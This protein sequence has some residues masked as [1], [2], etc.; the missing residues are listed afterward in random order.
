MSGTPT[1]NATR[2]LAA[3]MFSDIVGY[4]AIMGRDE[5]EALRAL[6]AHRGALRTLLPK[7]NGRLIG[8][9]GDGTLSSFHSAI[10][11]VNCAREVQ[12][13]A[14][15][16]SPELRLRI[17]IHLGD[18]VFT[19]STVLGDGVNVASRI[20]A[21][22]EPGGIC[23]SEHIYDAIRNKPGI[24][25]KN[26]G[27]KRLKNVARPIRV[28][29]LQSQ[30]VLDTIPRLRERIAGRTLAVGVVLLTIA[31]FA[32]AYAYRTRIERTVRERV[33]AAKATKATVA[34]LPFVNLSASKDDEYFSDGMTDEIIGDL[35]KI[36]GL[37]VVARSSSFAFKGQN[38]DAKRIAKLLHVKNLLEGSVRRS[39]DKVRIEVDLIDAGSGFSIWSESY[40]RDR[41]DIFAI[42][43]DVA[44]SVAEKLKVSLLPE[45]AA[46]VEKKPTDNHDAYDLYLRG[47]YF[48]NLFSEEDDLKAIAY[49][50]RAIALDP[51]FALA[52]AALA[53]VYVN[54]TDWHFAPRESEPIVKTESERALALDDRLAEP[55]GTLGAYMIQY[56]WDWPAA[57][58]EYRRAIEIAPDD[59]ETHGFYGFA[60]GYM[61]RY[62]DA[63]R[64]LQRAFEVDPL[65][66]IGFVFTGDVYAM[67]RDYARARQCYQRV[68]DMDPYSWVGYFDRGRLSSYEGNLPAAIEDIEKAVTLTDNP[69]V[70]GVLGPLYARAGRRADTLK[71]LAELRDASK[72]RFVS[73]VIFFGLYG[74]LGDKAQA[75]QSLD[76]AYEGRSLL[77]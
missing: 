65:D 51:N 40:D 45:E 69:M 15:E 54:S 18:V 25:A 12:A 22:A 27:N 2:E 64:E 68:V 21:L 7:F 28:Y 35:S 16:K 71:L 48:H 23:I 77:Q 19:N 20:H 56:E 17:G 3:I 58:R 73:P 52:H 10:D 67:R 74:A 29:A 39:A 59:P 24:Y 30:A 47:R 70:K 61:G 36:N 11:A 43:S 72:H 44:E 63:L 8:E 6:D 76:E 14:T 9:I 1:Q 62:D 60:L 31:A 33:P 38:G 42:Q 53:T 26:L 32:G 46:R 55:H 34:V 37:Q 57:E 75:N 13:L 4:T 5:L 41:I 50:K 49:L 66:P